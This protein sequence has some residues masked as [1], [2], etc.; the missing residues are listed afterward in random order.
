M[1]ELE[2]WLPVSGY[3]GLYEVSS[4]GRVRSVD[5][6]VIQ[7]GGVWRYTGQVLKPDV[8]ARGYHRVGLSQGNRTRTIN[9]HRLVAEAHIPNPEG[10]P[11][12]R[13][14]DDDRDNNR[15]LN[16]AWGTVA[17]NGADAVRNGVHNQTRKT[18]CPQNH[19]Y[20]EGNT[21]RGSSGT[22]RKCRKCH[23]LKERERRKDR[24]G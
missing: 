14:L 7:K 8:S 4:L 24:R 15:C 18:H 21:Y 16:L 22:V 23:A 13:H 6:E 17:D 5:H 12:V 19:E 2:K 10:Y 11:L 1:D 9:V 3:E 20:S